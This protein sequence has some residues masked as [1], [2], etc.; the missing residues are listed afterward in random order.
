MTF[1]VKQSFVGCNKWEFITLVGGTIQQKNGNESNTLL[2]K[3]NN[4]SKFINFQE[5]VVLL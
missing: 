5:K 4:S 3:F 2:I 1:N